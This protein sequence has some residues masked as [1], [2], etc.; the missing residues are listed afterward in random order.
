MKEVIN[1][2]KSSIIDN[3]D[4]SS[5]CVFENLCKDPHHYCRFVNCRRLDCNDI[6]T[7]TPGNH[8][9]PFREYYKSGRLLLKDGDYVGHFWNWMKVIRQGQLFIVN[10]ATL[11]VNTTDTMNRLS[12][13]LDLNS[14]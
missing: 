6:N 5:K 3:Q 7:R 14:T 4:G 13:F 2:T 11:V 10:L 12:Q 9:M 1:Q 8:L